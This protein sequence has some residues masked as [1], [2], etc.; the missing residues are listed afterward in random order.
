MNN[1]TV[2][3]IHL[4]NDYFIKIRRIVGSN[5]CFIE[6]PENRIENQPAL[7]THYKLNSGGLTVDYG[8]NDGW[9]IIGPAYALRILILCDLLLKIADHHIDMSLIVYYNENG[10]HVKDGGIFK[11][12][13][14][15]FEEDGE[16]RQKELL[17][18]EKL[19][20]LFAGKSEVDEDELRKEGILEG[21]TRI[22]EIFD[23]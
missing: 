18:Y 2:A 10:E 13:D 9:K 6:I 12:I 8:N 20:D 22:L 23:Y 7:K 5:G 21:Y 3:Q 4:K 14:S 16:D 11:I 17:L 19:K 1:R 15:P